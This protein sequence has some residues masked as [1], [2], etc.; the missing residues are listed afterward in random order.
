MNAK[1]RQFRLIC[2]FTLLASCGPD[3][4]DAWEEYHPLILSLVQPF[5]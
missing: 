2:I 3:L 1:Y 5:T 4:Q